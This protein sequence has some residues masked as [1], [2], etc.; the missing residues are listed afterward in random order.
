[1]STG[2]TSNQDQVDGSQVDTAQVERI[3]RIVLRVIELHQEQETN[4]Y[5][6]NQRGLVARMF[7]GL[8]SKGVTIPLLIIALITIVGLLRFGIPLWEVPEVAAEKYRQSY[9]RSEQVDHHIALGESFLDTGLAQAA[10][11]EFEKAL[12][13]EPANPEAQRGLFKAELFTPIE[14]DT[15]DPA[16]AQAQ[17]EQFLEETDSGDSHVYAY[18][19]DIISFT[20]REK[21]LDYYQRAIKLRSTNSYALFGMGNVYDTQDKLELAKQKFQAAGDL[22]SKESVASGNAFAYGSQAYQHNYAYILYRQ[23]R[24]QEAAR[25]EEELLYWDPNYVPAYYA[26]PGFY[27]LGW[28][29]L[30]NSLRYQK[31]LISLLKDER[32]MAQERNSL[33]LDAPFYTGS[34]SAPV[35][36]PELPAHQYYVYYSTALTSYLRG[37]HKEAEVYVETARKLHTDGQVDDYLVLEVERLVEFD[38]KTL[39]Q[40]Q[41]H[42]SP[43]ADEFRQEFL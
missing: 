38:I 17:F 26:L 1:M 22:A 23:K 4:S 6:S 35:Y 27:Q 7:S 20:N 31:E 11:V 29:D 40:A 41:P 33:I 39:L 8:F 16:V 25:A 43:G 32:I 24:Y 19:G 30:E 3:T 2:D 21:A 42:F 37:N 36:L 15:Y 28:G 14:E 18:L 13:L 9:L 5:E 12:E 34:R 10:K